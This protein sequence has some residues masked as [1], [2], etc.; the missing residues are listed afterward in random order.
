MRM[1]ICA[2]LCF[3]A[4]CTPASFICYFRSIVVVAADV[5]LCTFLLTVTSP[6]LLA[7]LLTTELCTNIRTY[8]HTYICMFDTSSY[9]YMHLCMYVCIYLVMLTAK[10]G[11]TPQL[12]K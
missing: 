6:A 2:L 5:M 1:C 3:V 7:P 9:T 8:I 4:A 10:A 11:K 12:S